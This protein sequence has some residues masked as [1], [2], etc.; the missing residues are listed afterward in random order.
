[1]ALKT[2]PSALFLGTIVAAAGLFSLS[3][4][5]QSN[6]PA[7]PFQIGQRIGVPPLVSKAAGTVIDAR[8]SWLL[9]NVDSANRGTLIAGGL[10]WFNLDQVTAVV[11]EPTGVP[12][13][14]L[15]PGKVQRAKNDIMAIEGATQEFAI[16]N[17]MKYP[18]SIV[19]LVTPDENGFTFLKGTEVPKDPWGNEY[20][21]QAPGGALKVPKILTLGADGVPG[22]EARIVTSTTS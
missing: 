21:Y 2:S 11:P 3:A 5:T 19:D 9:V 4:L 15:P 8:G 12:R 13:F 20:L 1:M 16:A 10:V 7:P 17:S 18:D 6:D 22:G 14:V